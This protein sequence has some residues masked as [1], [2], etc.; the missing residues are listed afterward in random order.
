MFGKKSGYKG[1]YRISG[2]LARLIGEEWG[3]LPQAGDHWVEYLAVSR[4]HPQDQK[5]IDVRIFDSW[6]A[7]QKKV[8]V[9]DFSSLD[10]HPDLILMEGW[11]DEKGGKGS[12]RAKAA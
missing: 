10:G 9:K 5:L 1:P 3:K 4:P 12:I 11:C 2:S 6:C 8:D 7:A